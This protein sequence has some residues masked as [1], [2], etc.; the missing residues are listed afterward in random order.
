MD[1]HLQSLDQVK[2]SVIDMAIKFG[3][4]L[5]VALLILFAAIWPGA[6]WAAASTA[7]CFA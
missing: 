7:C 2:S 5:V 4:K 6:G 3:P 1:N